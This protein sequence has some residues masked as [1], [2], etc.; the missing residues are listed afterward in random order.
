MSKKQNSMLR[1]INARDCHI[2]T[3]DFATEKIFLEE[4]HEQGQTQSIICYGLYTKEEELVKILSLGK[5]RFNR[6]YQW[7]V[8][9]DCSKKDVEVRGGLSKLWKH[10]VKENNPIDVICYSY[11]KN[12][13]FISKYVDFCG[14][15]NVKKVKPTKKICFKGSWNG[16]ERKIDKTILEVHGVDRLLNGSFGQDRT[17]EQI[18]LD[19]GFKKETYDGLE[20][21]VDSWF[22]GGCVYRMEIIGTD[23]FYI[24]KTIGGLGNYWGSGTEWLKY[25]KNN[26]IPKDDEH[27]KKIILKDD[28]ISHK[29]LYDAESKFIK[30]YCWRDDE[31]YFHKLEKFEN[32]MLNVNLNEQWIG[33]FAVCPECGVS[34]AKH[35]KGCSRYKQLTPCN[36]CGALLGHKKSCSKYK[37]AERCPEC[38]AIRGHKNTCSK[39]K[40]HSP[41][42][43]CGSIGRHKRT[44]SKS[45]WKP[46]SECGEKV[47]HKETCSKFK[48]PYI[49]SE[50]GGKHG[51][52]RNTCSKFKSFYKCPECGVKGGHKENCSLIKCPECR[53]MHGEHKK[54]CSH[55][56]EPKPCLECGG[57]Q[58]LHKKGCSKY[59]TPKKPK[60]CPECGAI[61]GHLKTCSK[62]KRKPCKECGVMSGPHKKF[63]SK[64]LSRKKKK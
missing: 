14:F 37:E 56:I 4:N 21:Q 30:Q 28:C 29:D 25:L 10:F 49:C 38:G 43:E 3:V 50:C 19:L 9:R 52:H 13:D 15:K 17:N 60:P 35:K 57:K 6:N 18:L 39:F 62:Y 42:P 7:E 46:C 48:K 27:I 32:S 59:K 64:H 63:C 40:P 61:R 53:L 23:K 16:Q 20:P 44:C 5:P 47:G 34:R 8:I 58:G 24:G 36:E 26:N 31:G 33:I 54:T 22:R 41:C 12:S 11:P 45:T 2:K 51:M 55:Y 1:K